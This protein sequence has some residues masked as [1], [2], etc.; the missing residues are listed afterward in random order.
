[1]VTR[2]GSESGSMSR[3]KAVFGCALSRVTMAGRCQWRCHQF[4]TKTSQRPER[5]TVNVLGLVLVNLAD[6]EFTVGGLGGAIT[7][8]QVVDDQTQDVAAGHVGNGGLNLGDVGN[9]IAVID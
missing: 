5:L 2:L 4:T 6:L 9:G 1:L 3:A 7:A 8:G